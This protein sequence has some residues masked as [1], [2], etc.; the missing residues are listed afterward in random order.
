MQPYYER[1]GN[2]P[3]LVLIHGAFSDHRSNWEFVLPMLSKHFTVYAIAR[4]GRGESAK[5]TDH[6]VEDEARDAAELIE[7]IGESV[8]LLGH[9]YGAH[10]ALLTATLVPDRV[11][12]LVVYEPARADI[13]PDSIW[14]SLLRFA[15]RRDWDN[16]ATTFFGEVLF[17]PKPELDAVRASEQIWQPILDDAAATLHDFRALREYDFNP[18]WFESIRI[19]VLLQVGSESPR[20]LYVTDD[21]AWVLPDATIGTLDGQA[22]EGMT[23]APDQYAE[24]VIRFLAPDTVV[25]LP[26]TAVAQVVG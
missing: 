22:H 24:A 13:I 3:A 14:N 15:G 12:K 2:G 26:N 25:P 19:P 17:V 18:S 23:T 1:N 21:L 11:G 5:T 16:F 6:S 20:Q 8:F 7:S 9:S 10:V 4:R